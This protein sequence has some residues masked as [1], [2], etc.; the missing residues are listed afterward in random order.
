MTIARILHCGSVFLL[1]IN[2]DVTISG[3]SYILDRTLV[4]QQ[5]VQCQA[6]SQLQGI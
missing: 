3:N 1:F 5:S 2:T 4:D 6:M